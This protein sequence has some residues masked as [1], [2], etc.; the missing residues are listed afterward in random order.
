MAAPSSTD[1]EPLLT[2][3]QVSQLIGRAVPTLQKDRLRGDGPP[4]LKVGR[5]V[6]Y[7]PSDVKAWLDA[8]AYKSTAEYADDPQAA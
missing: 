1:I 5:H 3:N 7:R 6:R 8:R 2:E 4:F